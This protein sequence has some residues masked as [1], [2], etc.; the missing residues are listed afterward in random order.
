MESV[1]GRVAWAAYWAGGGALGWLASAK[2]VGSGI[3]RSTMLLPGDILGRCIVMLG[4]FILACTA[5]VSLA[6]TA[7]GTVSSMTNSG[8]SSGCVGGLAF[9]EVTAGGAWWCGTTAGL[10]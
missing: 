5:A 9:F 4:V 2:L 8:R 3:V 1:L 6:R 10:G 7:G